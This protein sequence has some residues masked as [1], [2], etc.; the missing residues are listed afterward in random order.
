MNEE[1]SELSTERNAVAAA[2]PN[3]ESLQCNGQVV[4]GAGVSLKRLEHHLD[5]GKWA[6]AP[7]SIFTGP[8]DNS[9]KAQGR[10]DSPSGTVG[11]ISYQTS[12]DAVIVIHFYV[13][14]SG[15][16]D[17]YIYPTGKDKDKYE[18][19]V[20]PV[21]RS[22]QAISPVYTINKKAL[23]P[24][25]ADPNELAVQPN[26]GNRICEGQQKIGKGVSLSQVSKD[27]KHG[28]WDV[29]P[30]FSITGPYDGDFLARGRDGD[31]YGTEGTIKYNASD[32]AT[33]FL[34]FSVPYSK[35]NSAGIRCE[36]KDCK[37]YSYS[38][39]PVPESGYKTT[40]AYTI[41]RK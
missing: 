31:G 32:E 9:W 34:D 36:G 20:T 22:G 30:A 18:C 15:N 21:P 38:V 16:N 10:Q 33:F 4:L 37:L 3:Y 41:T 12:D 29:N 23:S 1:V 8:G 13:P 24:L 28:K 27:L 14:Y 5:Y 35:S 40:P 7:A 39:S 17:A 11:R 6:V 19:S 25:K 26:A 2:Q